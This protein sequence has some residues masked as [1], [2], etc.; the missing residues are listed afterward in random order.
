M[1]KSPSSD[2][3][4][5]SCP[6]LESVSERTWRSVFRTGDKTVRRGGVWTVV[7]T[8]SPSLL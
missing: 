7:L 6:S 5:T 8:S 3:Q 2:A 1:T 4:E